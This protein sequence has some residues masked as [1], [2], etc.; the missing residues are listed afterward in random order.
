MPGNRDLEVLAAE[1]ER[2]LV[3]RR[4][5]DLHRLLEHLA[6]EVVGGALVGVV[7]GTDRHALLVEVE[8]LTGHRAT[9]DTED[10][11]PAGQVVQRGEVLGEAQRVPLRHDV[12]HRPEADA[13]GLGSD[14]RGDLEPVGN[15]LVSLVLEVVL[16]RP[17]R[18]ESELFGHLRRL[19][20]IERGLPER[21]V[22]RTPVGRRRRAG[23]GI[24][25]LDTAEEERSELQVVPATHPAHGTRSPAGEGRGH[26]TASTLFSNESTAEPKRVPHERN[27]TH[28]VRR[29]VVTRHEGGAE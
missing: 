16:G 19:D 9:P 22:G 5:H 6:V 12:E 26:V 14:P 15:D 25:H 13:R 7:E 1:G 3:E 29:F 4:S 27:G 8:H 10:R 23:A 28:C 11:P 18:L 2:L 17:E 24:V 20:V 21:L